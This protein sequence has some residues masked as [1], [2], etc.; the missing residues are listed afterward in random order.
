MDGY[1]LV[2]WDPFIYRSVHLI[3]VI[4]FIGNSLYADFYFLLIIFAQYE[5]HNHA[6]FN[7]PGWGDVL[8]KKTNPTY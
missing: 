3:I 8:Q 7:H 1:Y 5:S 4:F 6:I 2:N